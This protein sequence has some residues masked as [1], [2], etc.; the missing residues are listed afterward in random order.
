MNAQYLKQ[1]RLDDQMVTKTNEGATKAFRAFEQRAG[2]S[3][4][5]ECG[6]AEAEAS[7][8]RWDGEECDGHSQI[9]RSRVSR[10]YLSDK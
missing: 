4:S 9:I 1:Y 5:Q 6:S 3:P 2:Y 7:C 8:L 10:L